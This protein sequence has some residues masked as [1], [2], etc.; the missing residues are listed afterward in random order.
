[1][2]NMN[3]AEINQ[4]EMN[5]IAMKETEGFIIDTDQKAE[6]AL[7]KVLEAKAEKE[8]LTSLVN[9]ELDSLK[10][11]QA[12]IDRHYE[13][14]TSYLL[15]M[16]NEY[17]KTVKC[18]TTKTQATYELL[19]GK[20][21]FKFAK[22]ELKE[23][24][25]LLDWCKQNAPEYVRTKEEVMWGELKK[26]LEATTEGVIMANTGEFVEG[27]EIQEKPAVFDIKG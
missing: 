14:E 20:L 5:A 6:W 17:M 19:S 27:I 11:K 8:R 23:S 2:E 4:I 10:V 15:A 3:Q 12:E 7:K 9:S 24:P 13:N 22:A 16:L 18:K 25:E 1:M 21:V 26:N